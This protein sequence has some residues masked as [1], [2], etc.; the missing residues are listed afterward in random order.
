MEE[1][2]ETLFIT[3]A[4]AGER[5][6]K[7]LALRLK[8]AG[9]RTYFQYLIEE[10]KVLLNGIPVKKRIK[11][12]LGDEVEVEYILTPEL[13]LIAENIPLTILYED[14]EIIVINKAPGMVVHPA[15]GHWTGT[16]VNALLFHCQNTSFLS[17]SD[18]L[19]RPG[20]VHRLDKD[21]SG[22]LIA[23]KT[24]FSQQKLIDMFAERRVYKEYL[25]VCVGNPKEGVINAPIGRHPTNRKLMAIIESGRAAI[26]RYRSLA[27]NE[28]LSLV[29]MV[30]ETGR[31]HQIRAHMKFIGN[32]VL[33][34]SIYGIPSFNT[35]MGISRQMLHAYRLS[36][37]HPT[38]QKHLEFEAEIPQD[39]Q[40]IIYCID[41]SFFSLAE[42]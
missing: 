25:A 29:S 39:M 41:Q 20:I 28:K 17:D 37:N 15:T 18:R 26:T 31:T 16:F 3:E 14:E 22:L 38:S 11:P 40:K 42:L 19:L 9:S 36:F 6:D 4:E 30:I 2:A 7:I 35:K 10:G 21:T 8:E 32:P 13:A 23:A 24:A 33:G 12:K 1:E 27:H 5:L 34:D